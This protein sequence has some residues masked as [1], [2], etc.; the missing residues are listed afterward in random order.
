V[1]EDIV[2]AGHSPV[3]TSDGRIIVFVSTAPGDA[4]GL[5]R[6][7]SD[8]RHPVQLASGN[9]R[10]PV[11]T[12]D[13]RRVIFISNRSGVQSPW[14]VAIDGGP[15]TQL[16]NLFAYCPDVSPDGKSLVFGAS[17]T[18]G[19]LGVCDLPDCTM[20]RTFNTP[21]GGSRSRWTPDGHGIAYYTIFSGGNLWVQPLDGS[22]PHQ[23]THFTDNRSIVDFAWSR[24]GKRL[25]IARATA[26][27]D[28][29]LFKGLGK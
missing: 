5:W 19:Q 16:A 22:A 6:I 13:D 11:V 4:A 2:A 7:D 21:P 8:G 24:D 27:N 9:A 15:P 28:I 17:N 20:R 10:W 23:L 14:S 29:V 26:T 18:R 25:A 12:P 1:P 3:A